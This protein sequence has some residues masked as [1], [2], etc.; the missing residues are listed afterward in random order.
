MQTWHPP[1]MHEN[2]HL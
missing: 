2:A 1:C